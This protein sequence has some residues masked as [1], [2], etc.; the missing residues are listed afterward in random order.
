MQKWQLPLT[1]I[2]LAISS[3]VMAQD[4]VPVIPPPGSPPEAFAASYTY[5][6]ALPQL[7]PTSS[8]VSQPIWSSAV[9]PRP[10]VDER[11]TESTWYTRIDYFHWN[12]RI[13][14]QDFVNEEGPLV[15]LGYVH[16]FGPERIRGEL[17]GGSVG[18]NGGSQMPDGSTIPMKSHTNY[19]GVRTEYD[20]LY[21]PEWWPAASLFIGIGTR[22]W[23]R[24]LPDDYD[25]A[26]NFVWG[27]QETWWTVY[28]YI[29]LER[30]R[31]LTD[32]WE[33]FASGRIGATAATYQHVTFDDVVLYPKIGI[34][35]QVQMGLRGRHLFLSGYF[36]G[37]T[38][39]ESAVVRD[40]LQPTSRMITV[41]LQSGFSF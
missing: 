6:S 35:G 15:T 16:R 39:S 8:N 37:M 17:F 9:D 5:S 2:V 11:L 29:G 14:G 40:S 36:E 34:T 27:Y 24:D 28:P 18:Y 21:D 38:W 30:R 26:G 41:G 10:A 31:T 19:M 12:E 20:L 4:L 1:G 3:A 22:F 23:F 25:Q 33:F 13:D 32:E 7:P